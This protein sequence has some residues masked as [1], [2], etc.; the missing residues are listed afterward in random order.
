MNLENNLGPSILPNFDPTLF[1]E[2]FYRSYFRLYDFLLELPNRPVGFDY[3]W[4]KL[5]FQRDFYRHSVSNRDGYEFFENYIT[6]FGLEEWLNSDF[7]KSYLWV[8]MLEGLV[9][10]NFRDNNISGEIYLTQ[11]IKGY[12]YKTFGFLENSGGRSEFGVSLIASFDES[13]ADNNE[14][15]IVEYNGVPKYVSYGEF[16]FP[17]I[18]LRIKEYLHNGISSPIGGLGTC[19]AQSKVSSKPLGPGILTAKHVVGNT[20]GTKIHL[21]CSCMGKVIDVAPDGID[22]ALVSCKCSRGGKTPILPIKYVAPWMDVEFKDASLR[23]VATKVTSITDTKGI[24]GSSILPSRIFIAHAGKPGDSG[25]LITEAGT[26]NAIGIYMGEFMD[27]A[28]QGG[29]IA[30]H[31]FQVTE[32]MDME[33]FT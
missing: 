14:S 11:R 10:E 23:K 24:F 5:T 1:A 20:I 29:G 30:Q 4:Y 8:I 27:A 31:A 28:G 33:L 2:V 18:V 17:V 13:M 7:T 26:N 12:R 9:A 3:E 32:I 15:D 16:R 19:Y 22:A 21:T 25:A 6:R